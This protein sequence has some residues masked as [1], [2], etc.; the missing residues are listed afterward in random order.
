MLA[1]GGV[2]AVAVQVAVAAL[3]QVPTAPVGVNVIVTLS[4]P[5]KPVTW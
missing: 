2:H 5:V 1:V 4:P 3:K